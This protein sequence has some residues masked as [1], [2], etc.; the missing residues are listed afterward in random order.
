[1]HL[2]NDDNA[3]EDSHKLNLLIFEDHEWQL[4]KE[5]V[6]ILKPFDELTTYFSGIKYTTLSVVNPSIEALKFEFIDGAAALLNE[7]EE[8]INDNEFNKSKYKAKSFS[9]LIKN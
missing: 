4:L 1:M 2:L 7:I 6:K 9:G 8:M 5:I 3:K